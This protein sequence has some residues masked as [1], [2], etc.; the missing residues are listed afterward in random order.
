M[1]LRMTHFLAAAMLSLAAYTP[2][3]QTT[4]TVNQVGFTFV[5]N[6]L[7]IAAGDTVEWVWGSGLH[8]VT[9]GTPCTSSG[10]FDMPLTSANPLASFTFISPGTFDYFCTPHCSFGMTGTITVTGTAVPTSPTWGVAALA[11]LALLTGAFL[12]QRR[13]RLAS[14]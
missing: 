10:L 7:T 8:T 1:G 14:A 6:T 4:H 12:I 13:K 9:S 11:L 3:V 5:P 2:R